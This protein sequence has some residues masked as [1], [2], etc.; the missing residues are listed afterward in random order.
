MSEEVREER[1]KIWGSKQED[2]CIQEVGLRIR[3]DEDEDDEEEDE[4]DR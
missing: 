3:D 2:D 4:L 1:S